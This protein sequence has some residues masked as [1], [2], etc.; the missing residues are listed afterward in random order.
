MHAVGGLKDTI[1]DGL[2]G[3]AFSGDSLKNQVDNLIQTAAEAIALKE[4]KPAEWRK[5]CEEAATTRFQWKD[6][7][8]RYRQKLYRAD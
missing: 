2:N 8:A 7:A 6:S 3:L 1:Q 4:D 5:I